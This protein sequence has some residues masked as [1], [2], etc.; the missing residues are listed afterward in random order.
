MAEK[1]PPAITPKPVRA[2]IA[3]QVKTK[4]PSQ[5]NQPKTKPL[6]DY[7]SIGTKSGNSTGSACRTA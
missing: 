4:E 3:T 1:R 6:K 7:P 2:K 5:K